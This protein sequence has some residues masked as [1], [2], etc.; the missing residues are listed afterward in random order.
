MSKR[1]IVGLS[2]H[3]PLPPYPSVA[4]PGYEAQRRGQ[5]ISNAIEG[6]T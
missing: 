1:L 6:T 2:A 4:H 3:P 5:A